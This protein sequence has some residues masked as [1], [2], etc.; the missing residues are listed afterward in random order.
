MMKFSRQIPRVINMAR[1]RNIITDIVAQFAGPGW[2]G[3]VGRHAF[4]LVSFL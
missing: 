2:V 4:D 1:P 3:A